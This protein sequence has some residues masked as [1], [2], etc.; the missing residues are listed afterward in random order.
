MRNAEPSEFAPAAREVMEAF[1]AL[2]AQQEK[3]A[4]KAMNDA[5]AAFQQNNNDAA[6]GKYQE[7]VEKYFAASSYRNAKHWLAERK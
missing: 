4:Q 1:N 7:V 3:S 2:R 5:R 6:Y